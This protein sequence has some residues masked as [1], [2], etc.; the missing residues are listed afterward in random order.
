MNP[1]HCDCTRPYAVIY[2]DRTPEDD[3]VYRVIEKEGLDILNLFGIFPPE[4]SY[5]G[6]EYLVLESDWHEFEERWEY[7]L[8]TTN[9]DALGRTEIN[10]FSQGESSIRITRFILSPSYRACIPYDED[11]IILE[12]SEDLGTLCLLVYRG[13]ERC[14]SGILNVYEMGL[15]EDKVVNTCQT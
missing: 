14:T 4:S 3:S 5:S 15:L 7:S 2:F 8:L 6:E 12:F 1:M 11:G 13:M 10:P 9:P